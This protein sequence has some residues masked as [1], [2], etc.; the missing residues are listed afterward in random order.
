MAP[1]PPTSPRSRRPHGADAPRP[2]A[3]YHHQDIPAL[4]APRPVRIPRGRA[5][6]HV[7]PVR[8]ALPGRRIAIFRATEER[9]TM[10]SCPH[11]HRLPTPEPAGRGTPRWPTGLVP[12]LLLL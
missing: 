1:A 10:T 2:R 12:A 8:A 6:H 11:P 5:V 3:L 4:T 9:L 7:H